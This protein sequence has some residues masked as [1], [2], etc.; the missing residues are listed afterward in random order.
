MKIFSLIF[1]FA[2]AAHAQGLLLGALGDFVAPTYF[3]RTDASGAPAGQIIYEQS[4]S[5]F[6]G[7][8]AN[9]NWLM[10]APTSN[11]FLSTTSS[12]KTVGGSNRFLQMGSSGK[13]TLTPGSY[14]INGAVEFLDNGTSPQYANVSVYW[15]ST[16]GTD[17]GTGPTFLTPQTGL[18]YAGIGGLNSAGDVTLPAPTIRMTVTTNTDIYLVPYLIANV[19]TNGKVTSHV[20]AEKIQ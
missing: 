10:F 16:D 12:V 17:S 6:L 14:V 1:F 19:A 15:A 8:D 7:K 3:Q 9:G 5:T 4:S 11:S 18:Y 20:Y 13:L 2:A